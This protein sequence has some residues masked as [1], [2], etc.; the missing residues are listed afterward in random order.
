MN[1]AAAIRLDSLQTGTLARVRTGRQGRDAVQWGDPIV[2]SLYLQKDGAG[3]V[4]VLALEGYNFAEFDPRQ[5]A[6][7]P[8]LYRN[9]GFPA[10]DPRGPGCR[11]LT[12][13]WRPL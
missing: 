1:A 9:R 8:N 12:A 6:E 2:C 5:D 4:C 3:R 11:G 13:I 10:G 7:G